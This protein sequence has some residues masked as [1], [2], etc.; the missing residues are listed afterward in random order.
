MKSK[1]RPLALR[2]LRR[3]SYRRGR[4][5]G[6]NSRLCYRRRSIGGGDTAS[7]L[8]VAKIAV[9]GSPQAIA[10]APDGKNAYFEPLQ[11]PSCPDNPAALASVEVI[12]TASNSLTP[13]ITIRNLPTLQT[14]GASLP[15]L[16]L[17]P[18]R[19]RFSAD[20]SRSNAFQDSELTST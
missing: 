5:S 17:T 20:H 8:V 15:D 13:T 9:G 18:D 1:L 11:A 12:D 4:H 7:N 6:W 14:S 3:L 16:S 2:Q 10:I 19:A